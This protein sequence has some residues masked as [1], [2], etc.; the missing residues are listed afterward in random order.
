MNTA[1][2]A[3]AARLPHSG[4]ELVAQASKLDDEVGMAL[5]NGD[6]RERGTTEMPAT[7]LVIQ[8]LFF[9]CEHGLQGY[10]SHCAEQ[11]CCIKGN[12]SN[13]IA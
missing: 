8:I 9:G 10:A 6:C 4:A 13:A 11:R 1:L 5:W 12:R 7:H 3:E 2:G